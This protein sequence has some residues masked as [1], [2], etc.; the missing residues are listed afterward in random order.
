MKPKIL[1]TYNDTGSVR[2]KQRDAEA[3]ATVQFGACVLRRCGGGGVERSLVKIGS[4]CHIFLIGVAGEAACT[5]HKEVVLQWPS[6]VGWLHE[7]CSW[8]AS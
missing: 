2:L 3:V 1:D 6:G 4:R 7:R 5:L 8:A